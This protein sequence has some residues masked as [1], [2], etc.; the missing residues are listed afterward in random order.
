[1][2]R[3]AHI[4]GVIPARYGSTRLKGKVLLPILGKPMLQHVWE[5]AKQ[6]RLLN[7]VLVACDDE[8]VAKVVKAFGGRAVMTSPHHP[9]G[10]DRIA[11][12]VKSLAVDIVINVQGDEPLIEPKVI[13]DLAQAL[14]DNPDCPMATV[15]KKEMLSPSLE[16]PNVVKVVLDQERNALYFSRSLI[17]FNRSKAGAAKINY[18][19]HLGIYAYRKDFLM[20]YHD[21]PSS[22]LEAAE[23]LE[24]LRVLE[25]G[26]RIKTVETN[27][28]SIGVDVEED[29]KK[30]E[31]Y[32]RQNGYGQN[33]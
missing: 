16:S 33:N 5:R 25:A 6:S 8:R 29:I 12:A 31:N 3:G 21:L 23:Q 17:P 14:L 28:Q 18:F 20:T 13:D 1:M 11:E 2:S 9:S 10:T 24:Q 26:Y 27:F 4:I 22:S 32:L 19:K 15:V 7:D 30:V